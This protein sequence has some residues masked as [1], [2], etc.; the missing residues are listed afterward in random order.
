MKTL[1]LSLSLALDSSS[2]TS[3]ISCSHLYPLLNFITEQTCP[4]KLHCWAF[5]PCQTMKCHVR[6]LSQ[7]WSLTL[8]AV[9]LFDWHMSE[10]YSPIKKCCLTVWYD[11]PLQTKYTPHSW[12]YIILTRQKLL[13]NLIWLS[14][15]WCRFQCE[16]MEKKNTS[17]YYSNYVSALC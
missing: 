3:F 2:V 10:W 12:C 15:V 16:I 14:V 4:H 5:F 8:A 13:K 6:L 1:W 11:R 7:L 17:R 9:F